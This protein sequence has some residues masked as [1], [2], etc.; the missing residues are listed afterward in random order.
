[1][2]GWMDGCEER[3]G[4]NWVGRLLQHDDDDEEVK[5][6]ER[7]VGKNRNLGIG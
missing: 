7:R 5:E 2:D 4:L 1:M 6:G 3:I